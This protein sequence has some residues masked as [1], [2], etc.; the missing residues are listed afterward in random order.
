MMRRYLLATLAT[1]GSTD[2]AANFACRLP[3]S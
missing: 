2:D 1:G 3:Q